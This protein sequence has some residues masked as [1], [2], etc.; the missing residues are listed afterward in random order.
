MSYTLAIDYGTSYTAAAISVDG[1]RPT[2][3]EFDEERRMPSA[4]FLTEERVIVAGRSATRQIGLD[5][6]RVART[7]K[8]EIGI[9]ETLRL[10]A[11]DIAIVDLVAATLGKVL[12]EA[13][14]RHNSSD[15][16]A[17]ILTHPARW[18]EGRISVLLEA[19]KAAGMPDPAF[20]PE[21]VGAALYYASDQVPVGGYVAVYDLGG[22]TFD[23]AVLLRTEDGFE[24]AGPTG[25]N[26]SVGGEAFDDHLTEHLLQVLAI[27]DGELARQLAGS[28]TRLT[29]SFRSDVRDAKE[30]LS[31]DVDTRLPIGSSEHVLTVTRPELESLVRDDIESSVDELADTIERSN[32]GIDDIAAIYL[33]GGSSRIPLVAQTI[34]RRLGKRPTTYGDPKCVVSLGAVH[35]G[36]IRQGDPVTSVAA[37]VHGASELARASGLNGAAQFLQTEAER[38]ESTSTTLVV[39]GEAKRG[40]SMLINAL[41][42]TPDLLPVDFD[43][44]TSVHLEVRAAP[45][46][47]AV[48]IDNEGRRTTIGW[49]SIERYASMGGD[50]ELVRE[51]SVVEV[52][53][54][55]PLLER[56]LSLIDTPGVAGL[57]AGHTEIT[58]AALRFADALLFVTDASAELTDSEVRFL[59]RAT[60]RIDTVFFAVTKADLF[61]DYPK[62]V[63]RNRALIATHAPRYTHCPIFVVSSRMKLEAVG[64][65]AAGLV[66]VAVE[67]NELS[68]FPVLE[69]ALAED[70]VGRSEQL[71]LVNLLRATET[72]LL[73]TIA[74]QDVRR[75]SSE[76]DAGLA[77]ELAQEQERHRRLLES[78]ARWAADLDQAMAALRSSMHA[79]IDGS[80]AE[81]TERYVSKALAG[82]PP[83]ALL[84]DLGN[85]VKGHWSDIHQAV[86]EG[87]VSALSG[88]CERLRGQGIELVSDDPGVSRRPGVLDVGTAEAEAVLKKAVAR[89][90]SANANV[91][92]GDAWRDMSPTSKAVGVAATLFVFWPALPLMWA[93]RMWKLRTPNARP[94]REAAEAV[95]TALAASKERMVEELTSLLDTITDHTREEVKARIEHRRMELDSALA[96]HAHRAATTAEQRQQ[97]VR[98]S[99]GNLAQASRLLSRA[100]GL[101][102]ELTSAT[103]GG[104]R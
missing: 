73:R 13:R 28:D 22:G 49:E 64:E 58:L 87:S 86:R 11:N 40:K 36:R 48:V 39:V 25:G 6:T 94:E 77:A 10:G 14:R 42:E 33:A 32:L 76:G 15:P 2:S 29:A 17:V 46:P 88:V 55:H 45:S 83:E 43:V 68:G 63:E 19:A 27:R 57:E 34:E 102:A 70:L 23:T 101:R 92:W 1:G 18:K 104:P 9:V 75:R 69:R 95:R 93:A 62:I 16:A 65:M 51:T 99:Q 60:Q 81:L 71:R 26:P 35:A 30:I 97:E 3:L 67:V 4:V 91:T 21:P 59:E 103:T 41:V 24:L 31:G 74:A 84:Q 56:G 50:H 90:L 78:D 98:Q 85:A 44:A 5:P 7:P 82:Y 96:D 54:P 79:R 72:V 20:V 61:R 66:E 12:A 80:T 53:V 37:L 52:G 100:E 38:P 8:R 89:A 47:T